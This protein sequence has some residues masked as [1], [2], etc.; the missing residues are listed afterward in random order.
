MPERI[1]PA[2]CAVAQK[3]KERLFRHN[4]VC[5]STR[6]AQGPLILR[7]YDGATAP[8]QYTRKNRHAVLN[9]PD[10]S[11]SSLSGWNVNERGASVPREKSN[12][13]TVPSC[14]SCVTT[15]HPSVG[16]RHASIAC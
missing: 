16:G 3:R 7:R 6:H 2:D 13:R 12:V 11:A 8:G 4:V 5:E 14:T 15:V 9:R 1:P 10:R